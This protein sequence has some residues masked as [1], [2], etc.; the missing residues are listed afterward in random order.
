MTLA[1]EQKSKK[2][3]KCEVL[4]MKQLRRKGLSYG[5]IAEQ[6]NLCRSTVLKYCKGKQSSKY[7]LCNRIRS[8]VRKLRAQYPHRK[9]I[10]CRLVAAVLGLSHVHIA[11]VMKPMQIK[12]RFKFSRGSPPN[13]AEDPDRVLSQGRLQG[14]C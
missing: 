12:G 7:P 13:C 9:T 8:A 11:R 3:K 4:K 6:V 14:W 5:A 10:G 2:I 1:K